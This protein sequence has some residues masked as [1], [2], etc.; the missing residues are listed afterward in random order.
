MSRVAPTAAMR[1]ASANEVLAVIHRNEISVLRLLALLAEHK[2]LTTNQIA[3]IE[4]LSVRRAQ[5]RLRHLRE[6]G[7][8]FAFRESYVRGGTSQTRYA[9]GYL[10]ARLI[11]AQRAEKPP[12]PKAYTESLERLALWPKLDHQLGV[13][14]FFCSLAAHRNP[15]RLREA[16]R[17]GEIS[18]LTQWWS[19]RRCTGFFVKYLGG[20]RDTRLRPD[21]YGCWEEH[22]RTVRFFLEHDTGTESLTTVIHKIDDYRD[23]PTDAFGVLLF[24]VHS[25]R[26]EIAL[27]TAL[28]RDLA[29]HDPG[30]VIATAARDHGAYPHADGP[31]GPIWGLWTPRSGDNVPRRYRLAELPQRGPSVEHSA[32]NTDQPLNEAAFD[33]HDR[34]MLRRIDTPKPEPAELAGYA[35]DDDDLDDVTLYDD[36]DDYAD[37]DDVYRAPVAP[38]RPEAQRPRRPRWAA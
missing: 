12:S 37:D 11:A 6:L 18:G 1:R 17:E 10:G 31:A 3:A 5:D 25:A 7:V 30:L 26:R 24:S 9:L 13:N 19:E 34:E 21:G 2:V 23:F 29:G 38:A 20:G 27:R 15:A 36:T 32:S 4:F 33:P 22:G 16:G 35:D 8:V 14:D 28:R